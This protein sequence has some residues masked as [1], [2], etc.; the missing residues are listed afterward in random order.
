MSVS[1]TQI[2]ISI[3]NR[4]AVV[5]EHELLQRLM[6]QFVVA[7]RR[8]NQVG[9]VC[10][11]VLLAIDDD[12]R[13]VGELR[14]RLRGAGLRIVVATEQIVRTDFW[15]AFEKIGEWRE[16]RVALALVIELAPAQKRQLAAVESVAVHL[17]V[18]QLD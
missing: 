17:P 7:D 4:H 1:V 12:A 9:E 2:G 16:A 14:T 10:C 3:A 13:H 18:I 6:P 5:D 8:N 11:R 15:N